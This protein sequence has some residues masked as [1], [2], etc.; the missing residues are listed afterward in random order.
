MTRPIVDANKDKCGQGTTLTDPTPRIIKVD[1]VSYALQTEAGTSDMVLNTQELLERCSF[2]DNNQLFCDAL[3]MD[4][5]MAGPRFGIYGKFDGPLRK[6]GIFGLC[7]VAR[8]ATAAIVRFEFSRTDD[9]SMEAD[10]VDPIDQGACRRGNT[11]ARCGVQRLW[12][13]AKRSQQS[14]RPNIH[15]ISTNSMEKARR[16]IAICQSPVGTMEKLSLEGLSSII[17]TS[18]QPEGGSELHI[19]LFGGSVWC[20]DPTWVEK[21]TTTGQALGLLWDTV[22]G[23][24]LLPAEKLLKTQ[25]RI[26]QLLQT[27]RA[28]KPD[29]N[30]FLGSLRHV[31]ACFSTVNVGLPFDDFPS[32][33]GAIMCRQGLTG[34]TNAKYQAT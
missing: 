30:N 16:R 24:V 2:L 17:A 21:T 13:S 15:Q 32:R 1:P 8:D 18:P 6:N 33:V 4:S 28:S 34:A 9:E 5:M 12:T 29:L 31:A 19:D 23:T 25:L 14:R 27:D 3:S 7:V 11:I 10:P 20:H 26:Q 22:N